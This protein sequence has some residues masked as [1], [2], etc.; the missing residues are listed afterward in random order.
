MHKVHTQEAKL[1][2][3]SL[4]SYMQ[5]VCFYMYVGVPAL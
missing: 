2:P 5:G 4:V 3:F 1:Q